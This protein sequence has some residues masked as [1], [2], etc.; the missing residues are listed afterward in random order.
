MLITCCFYLVFLQLSL[1][2]ENKKTVTA[3][4]QDLH[5]LMGKGGVVACFF[6]GGGGGGVLS[7]FNVL[8]IYI[9]FVILL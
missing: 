5:G 2:L 3:S 6:M 1:L 7:L 9:D 8:L 4:L